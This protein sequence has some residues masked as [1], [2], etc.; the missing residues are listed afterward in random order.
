MSD[1]KASDEEI[2]KGWE[3]IRTAVIEHKLSPDELAE[4]KVAEAI[5]EAN[6]TKKWC[7]K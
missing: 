7:I 3:Q 6:K 4:C 2:I 1:K 5:E